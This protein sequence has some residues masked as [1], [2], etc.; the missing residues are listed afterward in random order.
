MQPIVNQ[1]YLYVINLGTCH[2]FWYLRLSFGFL[3]AAVFS[4]IVIYLELSRVSKFF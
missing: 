1:F 2:F 4:L 3:L